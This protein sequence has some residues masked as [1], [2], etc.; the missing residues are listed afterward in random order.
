MLFRSNSRHQ[1][2]L[3]KAQE[4]LIKTRALI[5]EENADELACFEVKNAAAAMEEVL[6]VNTPHDILDSIFGS[7]CIGK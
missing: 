7:F 1:A 4:S 2:L 5:N 6:G 3:R